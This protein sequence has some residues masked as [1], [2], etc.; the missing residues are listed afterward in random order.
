MMWNGWGGMMGY[1]GGGV[2]FV[3]WITTLLVWAVLVL[4]IIALWRRISRK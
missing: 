4:V 1:G 3:F 2:G